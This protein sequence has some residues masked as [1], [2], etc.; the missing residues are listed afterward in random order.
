MK[1]TSLL[2][3]MVVFFVSSAIPALSATYYNNEDAFKA[4]AGTY[5]MESF[6]S[7]SADNGSSNRSPL[8][9]PNFTVSAN[10][11]ALHI[12]DHTTPWNT[13]STDGDQFLEATNVY[14]LNFQFTSPLRCFGLNIV[15]WDWAYGSLTYSDS[16]GH[17]YLIASGDSPEGYV[18]FFGII[19]G[20]DIVSADLSINQTNSGESWAVDEVYS[21]AVPEPSS[22]VAL[23]SG[24][25][26]VGQLLRKRRN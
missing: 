13:H 18:R 6:E 8:T 21:S 16:A 23:L 26:G 24:V 9:L 10:E 14:H 25:C 19:A 22:L 7:L 2:A 5:S 17:N 4:A 12:Y 1:S 11:G 3:V 20:S 15:D